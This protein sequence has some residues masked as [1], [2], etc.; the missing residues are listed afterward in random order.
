[1]VEFYG[2]CC[3]ETPQGVKLGLVMEFCNK[4]LRDTINQ[5][6]LFNSPSKF[7]KKSKDH[8]TAL[9]RTTGLALQVAKGLAAIHDVGHVHRDLKPDNVL[10]S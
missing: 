9:D 5:P 7:S 2:C 4:T 3:E 10:V 6:L 1:M 8:Q